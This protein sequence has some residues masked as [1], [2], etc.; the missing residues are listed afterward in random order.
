MNRQEYVHRLLLAGA[1]AVVVALTIRVLPQLANVAL[2][3]FTGVL[4]AIVVHGLASWIAA[5]TPIPRRL[6]ALATFALVLGALGLAAWWSGPR[7]GDQLARLVERIPRI[8]E[9]VTA[10]IGQTE[11]GDLLLSRLESTTEAMNDGR[12]T[13][14]GITR[15]VTTVTGAATSALVILFV[16]VYL[17]FDP[18]SYRKAVLDLMPSETA[19][20]RLDELLHELART[21]RLW[22][23]A[24]LF[25][26]VVVGVLTGIALTV[27]GIPLA[28]ALALIAGVLAFIPFI[29]PIL[30]S[31]PAIVIGLG[32][33][34][35][36]ALVVAA[37]YSGIQLVESYLIDPVV[38]KRLIS[39]PPAL[40]IAA[41]VIM[42]ALFGLIGV[43]LA[44]PLAVVGVVLVQ[45]LYLRDK[46]DRD[47][48]PLGA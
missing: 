6:A 40:V 1:V 4:F 11:W 39:L 22:M 7:L 9:E 43:F 31:I 30:S 37:I 17:A 21:L 16:A 34:V 20:D 42:G 41:Q 18:G 26:M 15:V 24:R 8:I 44:T 10:D 32:D 12:R 33:S 3:L 27:A 38:E 29:G 2:V 35:Q 5:R 47:P 28:F 19:R 25:S 13:I 14:G 45:Q 48:E 36:T 46:L 23:K